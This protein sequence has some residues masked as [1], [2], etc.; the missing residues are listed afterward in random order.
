MLFVFYVCKFCFVFLEIF[1]WRFFGRDRG[2][3]LFLVLV[4][5]GL[6]WYDGGIV[7]IDSNR[8]RRLEVVVRIVFRY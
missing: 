1:L 4:N 3:L 2:E 5:L 8:D 7:V 6:G